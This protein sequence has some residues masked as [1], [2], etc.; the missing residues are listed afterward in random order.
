MMITSPNIINEEISYRQQPLHGGVLPQEAGAGPEVLPGE[1]RVTL[2][3][4]LEDLVQLP[5]PVDGV[6]HLGL[7][8]EH[9]GRHVDRGEAGVDGDPGEVL[10]GGEDH[11]GVADPVVL[12]VLVPVLGQVSSELIATTIILVVQ[13]IELL[14][15]VVG[16]A[17]GL[18]PVA[19]VLVV[20]VV[21][22]DVLRQLHDPLNGVDLVLHHD[23]HLRRHPLDHLEAIDFLHTEFTVSIISLKHTFW[24]FCPTY[25]PVR[26]LYVCIFLQLLYYSMCAIA[27]HILANKVED[28]FK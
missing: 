2:V 27:P 4:V 17:P 14:G 22:G 25:A 3:V 15:V 28:L 6:D 13:N 19:H 18:K 26:I 23:L 21:Q 11:P 10:V 16:E 5:G 24:Y 7:A 8:V 20:L 12:V 9:V 1:A